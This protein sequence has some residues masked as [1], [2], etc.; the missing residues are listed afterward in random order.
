MTVARSTAAPVDRP[1]P[2]VAAPGEPLWLP[3][4]LEWAIAYEQYLASDLRRLRDAARGLGGPGPEDPE[5]FVPISDRCPGC[6]ELAL[7]DKEIPEDERSLG[8]RS[9]LLPADVGTARRDRRG[10]RT[11]RNEEAAVHLMASTG[12]PSSSKRTTRRCRR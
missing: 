3:E 4:D 11:A 10:R 12:Y 8:A 6:Y 1:R 2:A 7:G 9:V 5:P